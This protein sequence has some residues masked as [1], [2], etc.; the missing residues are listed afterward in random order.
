MRVIA[1]YHYEEGY[2]YIA[3]DGTFFNDSF[4]LIN[5]LNKT[6]IKVE[7][8]E[9]NPFPKFESFS[10]MEEAEIIS[11]AQGNDSLPYFSLNFTQ[12]E[13]FEIL[14]RNSIIP[15]AFRQKEEKI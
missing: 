12:E 2:D 6:S 1:F 8:R 14:W 10:K 7:I 3:E 5:F 4:Y 11:R 15:Y 13:A 9:F